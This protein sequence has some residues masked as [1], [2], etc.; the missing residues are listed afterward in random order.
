MT[1]TWTSPHSP[2]LTELWS[3]RDKVRIQLV[4][5]SMIWTSAAQGASVKDI[6]ISEAQ[7]CESDESVEGVSVSRWSIQAGACAQ[8]EASW[9][10]PKVANVHVSFLLHLF[11][12]SSVAHLVFTVRD[13]CIYSTT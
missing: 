7:F 1:L 13:T 10:F 12:K 3:Q 4:K 11:F 8:K 6:V 2:A 9:N 5:R